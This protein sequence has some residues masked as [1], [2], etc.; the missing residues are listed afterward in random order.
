MRD[1]DDRNAEIVAQRLEQVDDDIRSDASTIDTGS[2]A[3]ISF[4]LDSSA[5]AMAMRCNWPPESSC[6]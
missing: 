1:I 6:G 5:R 3:T 4:G 2:S